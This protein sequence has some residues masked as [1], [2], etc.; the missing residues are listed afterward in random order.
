[1]EN[2]QVN[3][4]RMGKT[5]PL[6]QLTAPPS[7]RKSSS[8]AGMVKRYHESFPS[9][10]YEFDSRYPL[11]KIPGTFKLRQP[12]TWADD[13]CILPAAYQTLTKESTCSK[14]FLSLGIIVLG[15]IIGLPAL[16][17]LAV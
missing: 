3:T 8:D 1:M 13:V 11:H 9:F 16:L 14:V 2:L 10:S 5:E 7:P 6:H 17:A 4:G 15:G 12:A